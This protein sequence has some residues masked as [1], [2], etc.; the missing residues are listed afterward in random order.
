MGHDR[1]GGIIHLAFGEHVRT[2][3]ED[4]DR[5]IGRIDFSV[6]RVARKVGGQVPPGAVDGGLHVARR[7][8]DA[9]IHFKL[10]SDARRPQAARRSHLGDRCDAAEL[11]LE[12]GRDRGRHGLRA[13]ARQLRPHGNRREIHLRQWR[14]GQQAER[15]RA[16]QG[17][18]NRKKRGGDRASNERL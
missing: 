5:E 11:A 15:Y 12:R 6:R 10:Q 13:G 7:G 8:V 1:G 2:Q 16:G 14:D 18:G 17:Y 4:Q 3:R 9:S